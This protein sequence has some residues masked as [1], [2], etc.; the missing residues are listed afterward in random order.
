MKQNIKTNTNYL[1][2][3][4]QEDSS[5][6][7]G[8]YKNILNYKIDGNDGMEQNIRN[9]KENLLEIEIKKNHINTRFSLKE[10]TSNEMISYDMKK[11][12]QLSF[13]RNMINKD[14]LFIPLRGLT[15]ASLLFGLYAILFNFSNSWINNLLILSTA[16]LGGLTVS[17]NNYKKASSGILKEELNVVNNYPVIQLG[18]FTIFTM[19]LIL[20]VI[21]GLKQE[22]PLQLIK[23][24][25]FVVGISLSYLVCLKLFKEIKMFEVIDERLLAGVKHTQSSSKVQ[26]SK[27]INLHTQA[28]DEI[29]RRKRVISKRKE[30]D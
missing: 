3:N 7:S 28:E 8:T 9:T 30:S 16:F 12:Y 13:L 19:L 26:K 29:V 11:G 22:L 15:L 14:K 23:I 24:A 20:Q 10:M 6:E 5:N 25:Y 21:F 4:T 17:I 2:R 27:V 18:G 1:P